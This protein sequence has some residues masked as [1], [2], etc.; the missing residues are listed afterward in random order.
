MVTL[1]RKKRQKTKR[2]ILLGLSHQSSYDAIV[3][4]IRA[5][6]DWLDLI[7]F[8]ASTTE[9]TFQVLELNYIGVFFENNY[10]MMKS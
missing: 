6:L 4:T 7:S 5:H 2:I 3:N 8:Y 9:N 1:K 10:F